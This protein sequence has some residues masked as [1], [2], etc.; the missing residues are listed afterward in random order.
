MKTEFEYERLGALAYLAT[1]DVHR[2]KIFGRCEETTGIYSF[3]ALVEQVMSQYPYRSAKRVFWVLDNGSS[4]RGDACVKRLTQR[5]PTIAPVHLPVHA[6]WLNQIEVYFSVVQR[7]VLT[8]NDFESTQGL[9]KRLI[10]FQNYY[11]K[12]AKP[13]QWKFTRQD[14]DNVIEKLQPWADTIRKCA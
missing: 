2:A 10:D 9:E 12:I 5:W 14:L 13:F 3:D 8:P 11:E 7:K 4:H 1:R 6:S